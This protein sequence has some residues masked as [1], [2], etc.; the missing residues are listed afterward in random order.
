MNIS[1]DTLAALDARYNTDIRSD[2]AEKTSLATLIY[3]YLAAPR[4]CYC[5]PWVLVKELYEW[6]SPIEKS[7]WVPEENL[8][9]FIYPPNF[10]LIA[11]L[12]SHHESVV[13]LTY[14]YEVR[15][16]LLKRKDSYAY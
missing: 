1:A 2:S 15:P 7:H 10:H 11:R 5:E 9:P 16:L 4:K 8:H 3:L 12:T 6:L 14:L 13:Y